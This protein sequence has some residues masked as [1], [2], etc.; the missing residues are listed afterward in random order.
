[1]STKALNELL[2]R[3]RN[4]VPATSDRLDEAA[5]ELEAIERA[6]KSMVLIKSRLKAFPEIPWSEKEIG[7]ASMVDAT[8]ASIAKDA[9]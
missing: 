7:D 5:K 6:A 3:A 1:M 2:Y 9:P 8:M 4:G